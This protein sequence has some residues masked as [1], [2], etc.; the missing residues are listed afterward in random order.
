MKEKKITNSIKS[1]LINVLDFFRHKKSYA[2]DGEDVVLDALLMDKNK[3]KGFF[4]DV[5]AHHPVRFSNT[6]LFS[7]KGWKGINIDPTPGSMRK[8]NLLRSR[9]INLEIGIGATQSKI[10]FYCFNEPA[11]NTFDPELASKRNN[12]KPYFITKTRL[13]DVFPLSDVFA[14]YVSPNQQ[15]DFMTVDVEGLDLAVLQSNDWN[16]YRPTYLLVEDVDFLI[17]SPRDSEVYQFINSV[18]YSVVSVL[19]RTI[20]F[21]DSTKNA[22]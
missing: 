10:N 2:Q 14:A 12:Q 9:D 11:L 8:F 5:G 21:I 19:K 13:V 1:M 4:V 20:I 22:L 16:L 15:I 6:Y 3:H 18:G 7:K 17:E